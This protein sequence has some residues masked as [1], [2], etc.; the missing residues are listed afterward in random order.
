[1][2]SQIVEYSS[3]QTNEGVRGIVRYEREIEGER[4]KKKE[5]KKGRQISR[6]DIKSRERDSAGLSNEEEELYD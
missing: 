6:T 5:R 3:K 4:E 1:M 2:I